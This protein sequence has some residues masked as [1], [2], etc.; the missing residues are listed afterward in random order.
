MADISIG[1]GLT[2]FRLLR[3]AWKG[4]VFAF[5]N[6]YAVLRHI[7]ADVALKDYTYTQ[8]RWLAYTSF[9]VERQD[10]PF[11]QYLGRT[12]SFVLK[13]KGPRLL[14]PVA[15][16]APAERIYRFTEKVWM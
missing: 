13:G 7:H 11:I 14:S 5:K 6:P 16:P 4:L 12:G 1:S 8:R 2:L 3:T 10:G 9:Y 15:L